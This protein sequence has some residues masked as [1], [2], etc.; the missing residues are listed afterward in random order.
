M[1]VID[2]S[3]RQ[4]AAD[5]RA[6]A[7]PPRA[8]LA[9]MIRLIDAGELNPR[10]VIVCYVEEDGERTHSGWFQAGKGNVNEQIGL[11]HRTGTALLDAG[12]VA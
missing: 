10:H 9:E 11:L 5:E 12:R 3:A 1:S 2:L 4:W 6:N 8:A 7:H